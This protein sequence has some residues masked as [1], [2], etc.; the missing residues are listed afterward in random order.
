MKHPT[1]PCNG[2][3]LSSAQNGYRALLFDFRYTCP[4]HK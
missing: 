1:G 3:F 2:H 4:R